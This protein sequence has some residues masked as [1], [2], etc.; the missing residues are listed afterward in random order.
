MKNDLQNLFLISLGALQ[1]V[2]GIRSQPSMFRQKG[3]K[4]R[5][6]LMVQSQTHVTHIWY[7]LWLLSK[8]ICFSSAFHSSSFPKIKMPTQRFQLTLANSPCTDR[9]QFCVCACPPVPLL[10]KC[11]P[12]ALTLRFSCNSTRQSFLRSFT[13][14]QCLSIPAGSWWI[15]GYCMVKMFVFCKEHKEAL[16]NILTG[17][18]CWCSLFC[19][20]LI[21][22]RPCYQHSCPI[23]QI[24]YLLWGSR[25]SLYF[26]QSC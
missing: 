24:V 3:T 20:F 9:L 16:R 26:S 4:D 17:I 22:R 2:C 15:W 13:K 8:H 14:K 5:M 11:V 10:D 19:C 18:F 1:S 21:G 23:A 25:S 6:F 12:L 7:L